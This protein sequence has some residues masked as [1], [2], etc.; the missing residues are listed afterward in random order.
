MIAANDTR[1]LLTSESFREIFS[2]QVFCAVNYFKAGVPEATPVLIL[3]LLEE[4][5]PVVFVT[6]VD[7]PNNAKARRTCMEVVGALFAKQEGIQVLGV[8]LANLAWKVV[9]PIEIGLEAAR[10]IIPSQHKDRK[11]VVCLCGAT[12]DGRSLFASV[13]TG[14][15]GDDDTEPMQINSEEVVECCNG[16]EVATDINIADQ[17]VGSFFSGYYKAHSRV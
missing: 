16:L 14:R 2:K 1:G 17:L 9:S 7:M 11:E 8:I 12:K 13:P 6:N 15:A 10:R 3:I 5:K 4:Q